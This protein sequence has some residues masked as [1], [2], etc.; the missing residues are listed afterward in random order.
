MESDGAG[1]TT[2]VAGARCPLNC[3]F[4]INKRLL[5]DKQPEWI[6]PETLLERTRIDDLYF[7]ATGG[8]LCFGGGEALLHTDFIAAFRK[9]IGNAWKLTAETSLNISPAALGTA[10]EVLDAFIVD[11]K[12]ADP[13]IY[14]SYTGGDNIPV[15][16]NLKTLLAAV[17]PERVKVRVPLIP[18]YNDEADQA[19]TQA[20]LREMGARNIEIFTYKTTD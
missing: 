5:K 2:L 1:V 8:G 13:D 19:R 10:I 12:T 9:Q 20:I 11:V 16:Q 14:R 17:P 15:L 18:G 4:C 6:T 7:Q 3:A